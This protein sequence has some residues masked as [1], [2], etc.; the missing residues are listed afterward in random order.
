MAGAVKDDSLLRGRTVAFTGRLA[1]MTRREAMKLLRR[2]DGKFVSSVTRL[3]SLLVIGQ[4]GWPLQ[5]DGRLSNKL[6]RARLLQRRG[7]PIMILTEE[8]LLQ[9]LGLESQSED[10][11]GRY[12]TAELSRILQVPRDRLRA[13]MR[14]GLIQPVETVEGIAYFDFQQVSGA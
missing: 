1:S 7:C 2:H 9:R 12:S 11:H 10:V 3:T 6:R 8:G 13:W 4:E 5:Q 14:A